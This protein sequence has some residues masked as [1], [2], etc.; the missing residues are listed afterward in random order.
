MIT[1]KRFHRKE[2]NNFEGIVKALPACSDDK[3]TTSRRCRQNTSP[4]AMGS[5]SQD[6]Y[7]AFLRSVD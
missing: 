3:D 2:R 6:T 5:A 1:Y 4:I 7:C